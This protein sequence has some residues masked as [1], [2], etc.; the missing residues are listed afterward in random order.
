MTIFSLSSLYRNP[1]EQNKGGH[2]AT[3]CQWENNPYHKAGA[4]CRCRD[5]RD[6]DGDGVLGAVSPYKAQGL[7]QQDTNTLTRAEQGILYKCDQHSRA[8]KEK[9]SD[10]KEETLHTHTHS[11]A[12][13][14]S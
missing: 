8:S 5:R 14:F 4:Q 11:K 1:E 6:T 9:S 2:I 12:L 7:K 10:C 13:G 3:I